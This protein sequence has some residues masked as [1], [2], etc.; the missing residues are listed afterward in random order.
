MLYIPTLHD[1]ESLKAGDVAMDN[2]GNM[3]QVVEVKW[4]GTGMERQGMERPKYVVFKIA[5]S[6]VLQT[7]MEDELVRHLGV[8]KHFNSWELDNIEKDMLAKGERVREL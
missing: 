1:I 7:Y 4:R 6:A 3:R 8:F 2:F 5:H